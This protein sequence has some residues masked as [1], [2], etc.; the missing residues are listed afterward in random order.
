ML[1]NLG[2]LNQ[3]FTLTDSLLDK[4]SNYKMDAEKKQKYES[5]Y[6]E[7]SDVLVSLSKDNDLNDTSILTN[8]DKI[9][10]K[11]HD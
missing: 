9:T 5:I 7:L 10:N 2:A 6:K 4:F 1:E 11:T 3:D 8:K